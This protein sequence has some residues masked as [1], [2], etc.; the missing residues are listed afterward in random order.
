MP[1]NKIQKKAILENLSDKISKM[2]SAVMFNFSGI[3]VKELNQL[4]DTCREAGVDYLVAKKT[5]LKKALTDGGLGD[6]ANQDFNGEV[7]TIFSYDDEIAPARIV[8]EFGKKNNKVKFVG[9]IFEGGY[10]DSAK[11]TEL[12]KIPSRNE[13]LSKVVGCL[14]NPLSGLARVINAIKEDKEKQTA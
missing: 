8:A 7:A 10:A 12:S 9:G 1:K 14:S 11:L 6:V 3:E 2:K 13:L 4:R 5:L